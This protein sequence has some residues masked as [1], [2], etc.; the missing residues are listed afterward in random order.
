MLDL[1][2][3]E[4]SQATINAV[5]HT[6]VEQRGLHHPALRVAAVQQR[7]LLARHAIPYQLLDFVNKPLRLGKVAGGFVDPY[8]LARPSFGAQVFTQAVAVVADEFVC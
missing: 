4:K 5:R 3:F 6:C 2:P 7:D 1:C 8:R